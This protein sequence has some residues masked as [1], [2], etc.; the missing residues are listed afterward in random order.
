MTAERTFQ[1]HRC[2]FMVTNNH[3][4]TGTQAS[5]MRRKLDYP[6]VAYIQTWPEIIADLHFC[7]R[8]E[9]GLACYSVVTMSTV[10][11]NIHFKYL[12]LKKCA[13]VG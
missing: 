13:E 11:R 4:G 10:M 9:V 3:C 5:C 2:F 12:K 1:R 6:S 7:F 8:V